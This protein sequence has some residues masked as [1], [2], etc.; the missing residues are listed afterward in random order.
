MNFQSQ[1]WLAF[2][3]KLPVRLFPFCGASEGNITA[4]MNNSPL[5]K[6]LAWGMHFIPLSGTLCPSLNVLGLPPLNK[7]I[8]M[9]LA[10]LFPSPGS[11]GN[12]HFITTNNT[13]YNRFKTKEWC[14]VLKWWLWLN[15]PIVH[16]LLLTAFLTFP[17][18]Y[19]KW[20]VFF[21]I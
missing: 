17:T 4:V 11:I 20:L 13:S 1:T 6:K 10:S 5:E 9:S 15:S 16:Y 14:F 3:Y 7:Y 12:Q 8:H 2:V 19:N 18:H 21:L